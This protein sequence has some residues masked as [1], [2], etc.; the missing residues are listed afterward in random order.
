MAPSVLLVCTGNSCRSPMAQGFLEKLLLASERP[1]LQPKGLENK[2]G[3]E[4]P[5]P[6]LVWAAGTISS[7][8]GGPTPEAI[9]VMDTYGIDISS[10]TS[11]LLSK[12][13]IDQSDLILV[14]A[15]RHK[16]KIIDMEPGASER[17]FLLKEFAGFEENLE[18][19]DP[20]GQSYEVYRSVAREIKEALERALPKISEFVGGNR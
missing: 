15:E 20:I 14:M 9:R 17:V 13:L 18:I 8:W 7:A 4:V 16:R 6:I 3:G 19:P 5:S 12:D 1:I 10:Y 11:T 2:V